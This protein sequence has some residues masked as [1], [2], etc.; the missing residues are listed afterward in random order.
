MRKIGYFSL[1]SGIGGF[2][3]G[4]GA[5]AQCVGF[6]EVNRH[7]LQIYRSHFD[8]SN[9]GDITKIDAQALPDF[10]LLV[11]G[12]PCQAF[13]IAGKRLGFADA[14]GNLF[15]E[16]V[17]ILKEKRP[18]LVLLE[19]VKGLLSHQRGETF[20]IML[21]ALDELG[22]DCQWQVLNS[23]DFGVA[24]S[25]E[26]LY[27]VGHL[28]G[29]ARP[30]IFPFGEVGREGMCDA[31]RLPRKHCSEKLTNN[32]VFVRVPEA[33]RKGY[34]VARHGDCI[35]L[36]VL[37][38]KTRRGRVG[39]N[40]S[41]TLDTGAQLYTLH[42]NRIRRLTPTECER[43][44]GFP[45]NWTMNGKALPTENQGSAHQGSVKVSDAQRY[46]ALGNA[47]TVNVIDNIAAR[48]LC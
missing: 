22:Y 21:M 11:G 7:A 46:K 5:R 29:T 32:G 18:R 26:R 1:F 36:S 8:H 47:V 14:R 12:F 28:R 25:R 4:I 2:E 16:I 13:S 10:E 43:L 45:D 33:T 44:Q 31:S 37:G 27:L 3:L 23:K 35:N 39:R 41:Q 24:Q 15:F 34:S 48:L 6:S 20:R 19:N 42:G 9:F 40:I 38:S 30:E 17:R